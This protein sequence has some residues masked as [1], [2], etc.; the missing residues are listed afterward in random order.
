MHIPR[1]SNLASDL[2]RRMDVSVF[3]SPTE[4]HKMEAPNAS[5]NYKHLLPSS[6]NNHENDNN[7]KI[8]IS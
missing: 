4:L 1:A 6:T 7:R 5:E 3:T 2:V 8:H